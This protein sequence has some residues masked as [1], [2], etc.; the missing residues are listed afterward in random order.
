MLGACE[1]L[2]TEV[3]E[4]KSNQEEADMR[5]ALYTKHTC[6]SSIK[7]VFVVNEDTDVIAL[8]VAK[9]DLMANFFKKAKLKIVT[10]FQILNS[11][12][13]VLQVIEQD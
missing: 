12:E 10:D 6:D 3:P 5:F 9:V 4:L 1:N 13:V 7:N 8:L 11:Y 2:S